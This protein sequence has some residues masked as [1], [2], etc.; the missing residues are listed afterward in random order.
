MK[1]ILFSYGVIPE[2]YSCKKIKGFTVR[3]AEITP[4]EILQLLNC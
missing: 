4:M 3:T 1:N 2:N